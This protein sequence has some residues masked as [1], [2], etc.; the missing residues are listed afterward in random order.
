MADIVLI[1]LQTVLASCLVG[2]LYIAF[3]I[4]ALVIAFKF[5]V[6]IIRYVFGG[7]HGNPIAEKLRKIYG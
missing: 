5:T 1:Y 3:C 7:N 2:F 4:L 6:A